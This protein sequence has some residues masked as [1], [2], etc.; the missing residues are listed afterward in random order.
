[1]HDH[2]DEKCLEILRYLVDA[3]DHESTLLL[4]EIV[5]PNEDIG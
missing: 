2:A 1:M 4:D 3:M 5:V